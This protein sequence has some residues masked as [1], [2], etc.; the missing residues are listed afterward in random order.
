MLPLSDSHL[1]SLALTGGEP[2]LYPDFLGELARMAEAHGLPV[3]LE[4]GG[5]RPAELARVRDLVR[6]VSLDFK[7]PSALAAPVPAEVF[8]ESHAVALDRLVAVKIV[9]AAES[10]EGEVGEACEALAQVSDSGPVILQPVTPVPGGPQA[11][12]VQQLFRLHQV[13]ARHIRDVRVIPQCHRFLGV[14]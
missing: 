1:H 11:P 7:L 3:Y 14:L 12:S 4:T 10:T 8:V 9:V 5:H 2:L 13:A 6:Y